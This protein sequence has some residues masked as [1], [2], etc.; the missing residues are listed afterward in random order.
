MIDKLY[1]DSPLGPLLLTAEQSGLTG[2]SPVSSVRVSTAC[3]PLLEEACRQ[4]DQY[5]AGERRCFD[6]PLAPAGTPFQQRVRSAMLSIPYGQTR[7]YGWLA[8][9]AGS[10]R[11]FRAAGQAAHRNPLPIIIPCHRVLGSD[12]SLTGF[13]WGREAKAF[14]LRLEGADFGSSAS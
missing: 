4:L 12:G 9:Q 5:F 10:P 14:L 2:L 8:Q 13:A 6:L 3:S 7:T 11:A 1:F